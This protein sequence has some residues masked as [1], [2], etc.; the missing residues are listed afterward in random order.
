MVASSNN[1]KTAAKSIEDLIKHKDTVTANGN[2][3]PHNNSG[4]NLNTIVEEN[5]NP[6]SSRN[7]SVAIRHPPP[8]L[9]LGG[10]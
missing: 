6:R 4:Q 9:G 10:T 7:H 3:A 5:E 2:G 1:F 8:S